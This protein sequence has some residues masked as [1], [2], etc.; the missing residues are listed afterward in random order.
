MPEEKSGVSSSKKKVAARRIVRPKGSASKTRKAPD[1]K[2][3][4]AG[5]KKAGVS[6][7]RKASP[8]ASSTRSKSTA[9]KPA[10][11][12]KARSAPAR[13][14]SV[15]KKRV[16]SGSSAAEVPEAALAPLTDEEQIESSKY[17]S[18]KATKRLFEEE[19]FVFPASYGRDRVRLLVKDPEWLFAHWDLDRGSVSG[20]SREV[21]ERAVALSKLT[22]R[23][24]D[25]DNGGMSVVLLPPGVRSWYV[26]ADST[27]RAY[28][29]ELG[30]TL[31]SGEF[32]PLAESN[33]VVTPRVGP[34]SERASRVLGYRH[35]RQLASE[36]RAVGLE[37]RSATAPEAGPWNPVP[38]RWAVDSE[39]GESG[40]D[41]GEPRESPRTPEVGGA[42]ESFGPS[43]PS[44]S[45]HLGASDVHRR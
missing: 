3:Q 11:A 32:R 21:G 14:P 13:K 33:T 8:G 30:L 36:G 29:A 44:G 26:R 17:L 5:T 19:R 15:V 18:G 42:S 22:L 27:P 45:R 40:A 39:A 9:P 41:A 10:G 24:C 43:A 7:A 35:G 23:I 31:P 2:P 16:K 38:S 34:S 28:K 25:P 6:R 4:A 37:E 12:S 20:L 1:T